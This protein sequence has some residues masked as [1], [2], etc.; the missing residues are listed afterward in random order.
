V[1]K[2]HF[3]FL[4]IKR[5]IS[6]CS[7]F[8]FR[9]IMLLTNRIFF[10]LLIVLAFRAGAQSDSLRIGQKYWEDQIYMSISYNLMKDQP[11]DSDK[12]GFSYS[13][14]AG[15]IKDIPFNRKG[16]F[17]AGVGLGYGYNSY[18][19]SIQVLDNSTLQIADGISENKLK[20]HD[21]EMPIQLRWR[22]SDAITYSFWRIYAGVKLSY[23]IAHEFSYIKDNAEVSFSAMDFYNRFQSG[24][25]ISAGYG[26]FNFYL[27][28]GLN[29]VYRD[30]QINN[31]DV[32]SKVA[33][34]GI[35]FYLL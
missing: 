18:N 28:Y 11:E 13:L 2:F 15:Y 10:L 33:K 1:N 30:V 16:N 20:L 31:T 24:L 29:S 26:A 34:F 5:A 4:Y 25:E 32:S 8:Y 7:F 22:T 17:S 6:Y 3:D 21:L 9:E 35:I 14:S 12:M 19:H 27:Y 23:N